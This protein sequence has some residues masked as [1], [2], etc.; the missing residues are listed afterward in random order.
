MTEKTPFR[1][2]GFCCLEKFTSDTWGLIHIKLHHPEDCQVAPQNN[3]TIHSAPQSM[4]PAQHRKFNTN[5]ALVEDLDVIPYL[6]LIKNGRDLESQFPPP[7][8]PWMEIYHRAEA[9][10]IDYIADPW[11]HNSQGVL[12]PNL[13]TNPIHPFA[14]CEE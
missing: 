14:T 13:N 9:L 8:Q 11:K 1:C 4:E 6:E 12:E 7:P 10:L 3:L 5:K 2:P